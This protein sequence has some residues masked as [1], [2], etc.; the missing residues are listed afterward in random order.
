MCRTASLFLLQKLKGSISGDAHDFNNMD[1][2]AVIKFFFPARQGA[3]GISRHSV[4]NI[5]EIG[6]TVC[7]LQKLG[8]TV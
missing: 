4:R 2:R 5:R 7:H 3:E 1:R 8:G 6:V